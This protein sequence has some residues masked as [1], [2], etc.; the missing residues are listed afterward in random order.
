VLKVGDE[1]EV[2]VLRLDQD[3]KRIGLS[4][5][6]LQPEPWALV[7]DK[8]ELGQLVEGLV[9]NVVDFGAFAEIEDG[10]E[11]LIH[12]SELAEGQISHPRDVVKRNDL[13]LLRI[14]RIDARRK[15]LGL[16]LKRVLESEW[17]EWAAH[18]AVTTG[19]AEPTARAP[20]PPVEEEAEELEAAV[21]EEAV[22]PAEL[23][24][25]DEPLADVLE[26]T[27]PEEMV[28]EEVE[29]ED[30]PEAA[31]AEEVEPAELEE[32]DEPPADVLEGTEPEE[33]VLEEVEQ[34]DEPVAAAAEAVEPAELEEVDEP[35]ADVLEGT[36]PEDMVLEEVEQEDEPAAPAVGEMEPADEPVEIEL[37]ADDEEPAAE[38]VEEIAVMVD[39]TAEETADQEVEETVESAAEEDAEVSAAAAEEPSE[40]PETALEETPVPESAVESPELAAIES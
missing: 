28:L 1:V 39:E 40:S 16:S 26:G 35:L 38:V 18:L 4:L 7:E 11:G 17:A 10:V 24:E 33:M 25:V 9:T 5:K 21:L 27:E 14:I 3:K 23:E 30:E 32:V 20:E 19:E 37:S 29:Q 12:V 31:A 15:R 34:E 36:E 22:E 8:Y 6:R 13:L 2:Y